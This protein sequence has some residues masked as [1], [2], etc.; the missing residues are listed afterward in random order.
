MPTLRKKTLKVVPTPLAEAA[1]AAPPALKVLNPTV[2]LKRGN[3]GA[4]LMH[5]DRSKTRSSDSSL[6]FLQLLQ[7]DGR[8]ILQPLWLAKPGGAA[9]VALIASSYSLSHFSENWA[10]VPKSNRNLLFHRRKIG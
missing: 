6:P 8:L 4:V 2:E 5:G 9:L 7:F 10:S 3:C 1:P